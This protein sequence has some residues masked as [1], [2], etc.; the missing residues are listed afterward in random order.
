MKHWRNLIWR[1][2]ARPPNH[3]IFWLYGII[4]LEHLRRHA[5]LPS[6]ARPAVISLYIKGTFYRNGCW[7]L[8]LADLYEGSSR[9]HGLFEQ[10]GEDY[11][12]HW[13]W[14]IAALWGHYRNNLTG[15]PPLTQTLGGAGPRDYCMPTMFWNWLVLRSNFGHS[16]TQS[17]NICFNSNINVYTYQFWCIL[18]TLIWENL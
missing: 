9:V 5:Y 11:G 16:E 3:Q 6:P 8:F 14:G 18:N 13:W 7:F 2:Q 10:R 1:S 4:P 15:Q 12:G 17:H